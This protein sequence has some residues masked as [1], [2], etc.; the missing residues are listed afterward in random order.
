MIKRGCQFVESKRYSHDGYFRTL[1][2]FFSN[3][4]RDKSSKFIVWA[5]NTHVGDARFTDM[6]PSGLKNMGQLVREKGRTEY[7]LTRI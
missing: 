5:P 1:G 7:S 2:C 3:N 6:V 4:N